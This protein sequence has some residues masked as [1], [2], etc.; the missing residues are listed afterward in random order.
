MDFDNLPHARHV[1][2][3]FLFGWVGVKR[4]DGTRTNIFKA[5]LLTNMANGKVYVGITTAALKRRWG[6]HIN[7]SRRG[8]ASA[9]SKALA[10][11]GV[12]MFSFE[13][14]ASARCHEDLLALEQI[15]IKQYNSFRGKGYNQTIGGEGALGAGKPIVVE[16]VEYPSLA[17][18]AEA[19]GFHDLCVYQR[20]YKLHWTVDQAFGIEP[21][22]KIEGTPIEVEGIRFSSVSEAARTFSL[23]VRKV[24]VRL[25]HGWSIEEAF[26]LD[27]RR[28]TSKRK[29]ITVEGKRYVSLADFAEAYGVDNR[30]V[31][32]RIYAYNW[33]PEQAV[34]LVPAPIRRGN[35]NGTSIVVEGVTYQ[36]IKAAA[37]A[38]GLPHARV[39]TR[40]RLWN[41]NIDQ[42]FELEHRPEAPGKKRGQPISLEGT[43]FSSWSDAAK[44]Y[45]MSLQR[46]KWRISQGW[47][48]EEAFGIL[49]RAKARPPVE[50]VLKG[51]KFRSI[52]EAAKEYGIDRNV[53]R[54]RL[55]RGYSL[56]RAFE[57]VGE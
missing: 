17:I 12:S 42:A 28:D 53:I 10:K 26:E 20:L 6:A 54:Q 13:H 46:I 37:D 24:N 45:G 49:A 56:E 7:A 55:R 44:A 1:H 43:L 5:Y 29:S 3:I 50:V 21:P 32:Q 35:R 30:L 33:T 47:S 34:G 41:W 38:Y 22:P 11:Y 16:G 48:V 9:I 27:E 4:I 2:A 52:S 57:G 15:L 40:L 14:V 19:Y 8:G 18:A 36:S 51:I 23:S 25:W 31:R 39:T